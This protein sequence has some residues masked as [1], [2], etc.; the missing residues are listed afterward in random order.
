MLSLN[1]ESVVKW[2]VIIALS[3]LSSVRLCLAQESDIRQ[4]PVDFFQ[5]EITLTVND[6][7]CFISGIYYFRNNMDHSGT[8]PVAFPFYIDSLSLYP[9][10]LSAYIVDNS[11]T[12]PLSVRRNIRGGPVVLN[13]PLK[14][15]EVTIW[16]LDYRQRILSP[17]AVYILTSTSSWG[18]PLEDA[19]YRFIAPA[20]F[21]N[22]VAWPE[23]DS[24]IR[25]N[26]KIE[27]ISIRKDFMPRRDMEIKWDL[28]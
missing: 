25:N 5:E 19:T 23:P 4:A 9:D 26:D 8:F 1:P 10:S 14:S 16:H 28:K 12:I 18:K 24:V 2:A 17:R 15:R 22:L 13:I 20:T 21:Q 3:V 27:Y 6:S 7:T 11:D